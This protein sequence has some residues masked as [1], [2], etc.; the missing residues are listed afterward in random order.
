MTYVQSLV[1]FMLHIQQHRGHANGYLNGNTASE[2]G[3]KETAQLIAAD[4]ARIGQAN[5]NA[6]DVLN[7]RETWSEIQSEWTG[8]QASAA[9]LTAQESFDRHSELIQSVLDLI[10]IAADQS[11]LSLDSEVE[12]YYLMEVMVNHTPLLIELSAKTRG[13]GNGI[14]SKKVITANEITKLTVEKEQ[15]QVALAGLKKA[16]SKASEAD[17]ALAGSM[18]EIGRNAVDSIA[19]YS[20]S[21]DDALLLPSSITADPAQYFAEGTNAIEKLTSV[22]NRTAEQLSRLL[23]E[24]DESATS[25]RNLITIII[26]LAVLLIVA[27]YLAFYHNVRTTIHALQTGAARFAAGDLSERLELQTKDELRHVGDSFNEMANSLNALLRRNQEIS[28]Q[29]AASS[30]QLSAVSG[31]STKVMEQIATSVG[32]I[33]EGADSQLRSFEENSIAMNE[34]ATVIMKIADAASE[35]SE[36]A[37]E[38]SRGAQLGEKKLQVS[39]DQMVHIQ[40]AVHQT[41][42]LVTKLSEHSNHIQSILDAIMDISSQT[43][44]LSLNANIEAARAGEQGRGFMVVAKEIGKL[45]VQTTESAKSISVLIGDV[46]QVVEQVVISMQ[47]TSHVTEQGI[48]NNRESADTLGT[49]LG[50]IQLVANQIQEVSAAAEQASAST[51]QVMAAYS[52]MVHISKRTADE[53]RE[54]AAATEEQL[55]SMEEVNSSSEMLSASAQQLQ[56]ELGKFILQRN[57]NTVA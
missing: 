4:I 45:A 36:A 41:S 31:E 11:G 49:I 12:S 33:S 43:H 1:P 57:N 30:Q 7:T 54:M 17:P 56:D 47:E 28:E 20:N 44:L 53:T 19:Q 9:E 39:N 55:S 6:S 50:S 24:R 29:V 13:Q 52:D 8:L 48:R 26:G 35:V 37:S 3:M 2:S 22:F 38:A 25:E 16:L 34:M 14:L 27:F 23:E 51:D 21:I 5:A 32:S 40:E 42:E 18:D 10:T 46:G 15:I